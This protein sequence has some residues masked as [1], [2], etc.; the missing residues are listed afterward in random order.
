MTAPLIGAHVLSAKRQPDAEDGNSAWIF[1]V[2]LEQQIDG[3]LRWI[4]ETAD[5]DAVHQLLAAF[6]SGQRVTIS[7]DLLVDPAVNAVD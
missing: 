5:V 4:I 6:E 7:R 2:V 1:G 3:H